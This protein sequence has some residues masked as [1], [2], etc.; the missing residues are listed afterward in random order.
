[1]Q[2]VRIKVMYTKNNV[3][4]NVYQAYKYSLVPFWLRRGMGRDQ[5]ISRRAVRSSGELNMGN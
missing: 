5:L 1:M 4:G 2:L 3:S